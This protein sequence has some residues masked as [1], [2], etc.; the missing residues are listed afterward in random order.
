MAGCKIF[1]D[2][3]QGVGYNVDSSREQHQKQAEKGAEAMKII[4][5]AAQ[6]REPEIVIR[7]EIGSPEVT[8]I[9]QALQKKN[10][11]KLMVYRN[12]EQYIVNVGEI[13]F[14]ETNDN[15]VWVYTV[16]QMYE[17]RQK[18]YELNQQLVGHSFVQI[19]KGTLVNLNCVK[20]IQAEFNGNYL[21]KLKNRKEKL[22]IS[23]K[24][25][26]EF[27]SRI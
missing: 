1:C 23:R 6:L 22:I 3:K 8:A 24:Y 2:K 5:E 9:L 25:F 15:K 16:D 13:V 27:K 14:L 26:K 12:E 18:L 17:A 4:L 20:S 7:G 10:S 11:G 21:V 19:N